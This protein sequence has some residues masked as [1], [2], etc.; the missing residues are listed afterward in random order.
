MARV[1]KYYPV[2]QKS[3]K[4]C[5]IY[6]GQKSY[7]D[8]TNL[9]YDLQMEHRRI[10]KTY[11]TAVGTIVHG[12]LI[13]N[14]QLKKGITALRDDSRRSVAQALTNVREYLDS[15]LHMRNDQDESKVLARHK[16]ITSLLDKNFS[17]GDYLWSL[18]PDMALN[19]FVKADDLTIKISEEWWNALYQLLTISNIIWKPIE[20]SRSSLYLAYYKAVYREAQANSIDMQ[21]MTLMFNEQ[22]LIDPNARVTQ[23]PDPNTLQVPD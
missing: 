9:L 2:A 6:S 3:G 16:S 22:G 18:V 23:L 11:A 5:H 10:G 8:D 1:C 14:Q 12:T 17:I 4:R 20:R 13:T 7:T 15:I 19:S 21:S